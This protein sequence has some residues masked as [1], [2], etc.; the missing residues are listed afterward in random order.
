M[1]NRG[2]GDSNKDCKLIQAA[3]VRTGHAFSFLLRRAIE[4]GFILGFGAREGGRG[5]EI[6]HLLFTN[7]ILLFSDPWPD[8]LT[9]M[10]W[11]LLWFEA[12]SRLKINL[13]KSEHIPVGNIP[14]VEELAS[15]QPCVVE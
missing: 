9:Y 12:S 1:G 6:S 5:V 2:V 7:D 3:T 13:N 11:V 4:C 15:D 10:A 14:N 8:Q